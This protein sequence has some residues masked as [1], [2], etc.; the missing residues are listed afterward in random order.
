[1]LGS[2]IPLVAA[3]SLANQLYFPYRFEGTATVD[4]KRLCNEGAVH[5]PVYASCVGDD[6]YCEERRAVVLNS[7]TSFFFSTL[8][9]RCVPDASKCGGSLALLPVAPPNPTVLA[10]SAPEDVPV[11]YADNSTAAESE[12]D[13][14]LVEIVIT[15]VV[16]GCGLLLIAAGFYYRRQ[17]AAT[18][19]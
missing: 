13:I 14:E 19:A 9:T 12:T 2:V 16:G 6:A 1:M 17:I 4:G 3:V 18:I 10:P 8:A 11:A 7:P 15:S 5:C